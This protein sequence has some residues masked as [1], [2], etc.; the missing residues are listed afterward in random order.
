MNYK[1]EMEMGGLPPAL[2]SLPSH[3][4]L[5]QAKG[6]LTQVIMLAPYSPI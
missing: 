3:K 2:S 1:M 6:H 4:E 5:F